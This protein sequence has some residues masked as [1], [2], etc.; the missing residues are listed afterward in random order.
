MTKR[1]EKRVPYEGA[2]PHGYM[3][4]YRKQVLPASQGAM[5]GRELRGRISRHPGR[6]ASDNFLAIDTMLMLPVIDMYTARSGEVFSGKV[7][8]ECFYVER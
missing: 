7:R 1:R 4:V 5:L 2:V 6:P 3:R 8:D